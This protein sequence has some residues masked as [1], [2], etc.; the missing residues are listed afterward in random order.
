MGLNL[1]NELVK[2]KFG[3]PAVFGAENSKNQQY[4]KVLKVGAG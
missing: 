2:A 1:R 3:A 4:L